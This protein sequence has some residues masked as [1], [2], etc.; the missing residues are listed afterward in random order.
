MDHFETQMENEQDCRWRLKRREAAG[1]D[2]L[3]CRTHTDNLLWLERSCSGAFVTTSRRMRKRPHLFL[4]DIAA[5]CCAPHTNS[6]QQSTG[7][8]P[9]TCICN[10]RVALIRGENNS[11]NL[12]SPYDILR[13][14]SP[15]MRFENFMRPGPNAIHGSGIFHPY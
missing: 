8:E 13:A 7:P 1:T 3:A 5:V 9:M 15:R 11:Y 6:R 14:P 12:C 10:V 2:A 4:P